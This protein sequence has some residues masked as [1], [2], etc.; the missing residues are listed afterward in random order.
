[1]KES[2]EKIQAQMLLVPLYLMLLIELV[3]EHKEVPAS[4]TELY[5][6]FF[7]M[8][9]GREDKEKGIE[10]LFDYL[11]KKKFLGALA[12]NEF[13]NKNKL[14]IAGE[15]LQHFLDSYAAQYGWSS[16]RLHGFVQ[17]IERTGILDQR[18]KVNFKHRS[19]LDY[20]AAF[21]IY[22]NRGDIGNLNDLIVIP[23]L[24]LKATNSF[25]RISDSG[26]LLR[27]SSRL[28]QIWYKHIF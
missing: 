13:L 14:E 5:D 17:E 19:F 18:D 7:D 12:Y 26:D 23:V 9:L 20:F 21:Y 28:I 27:I 2:L 15:D 25:S 11:I 22:E 4:V 16:E 1:M 3:E 6:R 10:V 24:D 8:A